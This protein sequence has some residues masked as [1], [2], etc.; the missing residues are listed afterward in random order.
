MG[1][2]DSLKKKLS[3]TNASANIDPLYSDDPQAVAMGNAAKAFLP[4]PST[5][6]NGI[7]SLT[8][9]Q[10]LPGD[11]IQPSSSPIDALAAAASGPLSKGIGAAIESE[12]VKNFIADEAGQLRIPSPNSGIKVVDVPKQTDFGKVINDIR[13]AGKP[14]YG[15]VSLADEPVQPMGYGNVTRQDEDG[16]LRNLSSLVKKSSLP[17]AGAALAASGQ[18]KADDANNEQVEDFLNKISQIESS[19]GRNTNHKEMQNGIH[20]GTSAFG[21]YGLLPDTI[22]ELA[23]REHNAGNDSDALDEIRSA[24]PTEVNAIMQ[25]HPELESQLATNLAQRLLNRTGG[26]DTKSAYMWNQG[27]NLSPDS[28]TDEKLNA[29]DYANKFKKLKDSLTQYAQK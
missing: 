21:Q 25:A 18:A 3:D 26:D 20:A 23:N 19:G 27:T 1:L 5:I 8:G 15:K 2:Y 4:S 13:Q 24:K 11:A 16:P 17:A 29:S 6:V 22:K 12:P 14:S 7:D 28:I 9:M 10:A